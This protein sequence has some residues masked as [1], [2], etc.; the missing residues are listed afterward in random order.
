VVLSR[1]PMTRPPAAGL[2]RMSRV[3]GDLTVSVDGFVA[4]PHQSLEQPIGEGGE[5]LHGW[6]FDPRAPT[7]R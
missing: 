1:T 5:R 7:G 4:G 6:L 2:T 3:T